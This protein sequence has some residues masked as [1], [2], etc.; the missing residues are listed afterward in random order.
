MKIV[1]HWD[2]LPGDAVGAP[3]LET[4]KVRLELRMPLL[5]SRDLDKVTVRSPLQLRPFY[6]T[7]I[8]LANKAP[9]LLPVTAKAG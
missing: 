3:S 8:T 4:F 2:R 9:F 7:I 1:E 6:D 5:T